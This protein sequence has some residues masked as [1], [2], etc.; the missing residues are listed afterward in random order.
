MTPRRHEMKEP[1]DRW[2]ALLNQLAEKGEVDWDTQPIDGD[3]DAEL[4]AQLK[5]IDDI[6]KV[7][8]V[9]HPHDSSHLPAD[10]QALFHWGQLQ[11]LAPLGEGGYGEVF[12]A[13]DPV[14]NRTVVVSTAAVQ[15]ALETIYPAPALVKE[16][17]AK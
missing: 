17:R 15:E 2:L 7:F 13:Y 14:L 12:Q 8:A 11:V 6:Q 16:L 3:E 9:K 10:S 5:S 4:L 1:S